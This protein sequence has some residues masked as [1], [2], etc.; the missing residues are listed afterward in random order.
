MTTGRQFY[1][2]ATNLFPRFVITASKLS[3]AVV[4]PMART[5]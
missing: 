2:L 5:R 4:T 1:T 3:T